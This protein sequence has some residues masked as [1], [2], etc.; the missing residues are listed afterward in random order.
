MLNILLPLSCH[1]TAG[2]STFTFGMQAGTKQCPVTEV[3][4][5]KTFLSIAKSPHGTLGYWFNT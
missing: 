5:G 1:T 3:S 4:N 2:P